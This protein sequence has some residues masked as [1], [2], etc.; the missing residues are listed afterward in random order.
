MQKTINKN[1]GC[2]QRNSTECERYE[3]AQTLIGIT[4]NN[5]TEVIFTKEKLMEVIFNPYDMNKAYLQ[6]RRNTRSRWNRWYAGRRL[7]TLLE[8]QQR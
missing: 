8:S 7:V 4:E 2:P 5:L 1:I 6:V 3:G